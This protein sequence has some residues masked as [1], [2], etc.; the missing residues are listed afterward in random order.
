VEMGYSHTEVSYEPNFGNWLSGEKIFLGEG[1]NA[2]YPDRG[3]Y[4]F[5]LKNEH[6]RDHIHYAPPHKHKILNYVNI[7]DYTPNK[8]ECGF[9]WKGC[10]KVSENW[11]TLIGRG[12][13]QGVA[14]S[15]IFNAGGFGVGLICSTNYSK[16]LEYRTNFKSYNPS[17]TAAIRKFVNAHPIRTIFVYKKQVIDEI[18][19]RKLKIPKIDPTFDSFTKISNVK[20]KV[21]GDNF[22]NNIQPNITT[23][24]LIKY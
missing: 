4:S 16:T 15:I 3:E 8:Q 13:G 1:N 19:N 10:I 2:N 21:G 5:L 18:K 22:H 6:I 23:N 24:F 9:I 17:W 14:E 12:P 20:Y 11:K 7:L